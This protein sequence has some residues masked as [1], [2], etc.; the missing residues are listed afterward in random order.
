MYSWNR[1][2]SQLPNPHFLQTFEW[3]QVKSK[4]GWTPIYLVWSDKFDK[5][6]R[7]YASDQLDLLDMLDQSDINAACLVLKRTVLS[8]GFTA[9]LCVLY[10]PKGPLLDWTASQSCAG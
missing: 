5:S 6:Y 1:L 10:A 7:S 4:Y 8:R 9:R 2:I 3:A